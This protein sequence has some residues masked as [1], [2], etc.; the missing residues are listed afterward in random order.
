M[1]RWL[2]EVMSSYDDLAS[3]SSNDH[4]T[5][6]RSNI[7]SVKGFA[8]MPLNLT[9]SGRSRSEKDWVVFDWQSRPKTTQSRGVVETRQSACS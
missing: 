9:Q 7:G 8:T 2:E 1:L 3:M 4:I 6:W 5:S